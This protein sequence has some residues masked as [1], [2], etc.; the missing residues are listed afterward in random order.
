MPVAVFLQGPHGPFFAELAKKLSKQGVITH[1]INF[2]GGDRFFGWAD[3]QA[4]F[5]GCEHDWPSFFRRYLLEHD[6]EAVFVYGDCRPLHTRARAV[7][8]SLG[9]PFGV[10]EE[11]YLRPDFVTF[12]WGG[13]NAFSHTDWSHEA[14]GRYQSRGRQPG[15]PV[16]RTF[17]QRARFAIGYYLAM[18]FARSK[19]PHYQHHRSRDWKTEGACWIRSFF[20]KGLY[21][22]T[23]RS[24]TPKLTTNFSRKFF[25]FPLQTRDDFQLREHSDLLSMENAIDA[26]LKSFARY[27]PANTVLVIKHHPM[28]RGFCH[29]QKLVDALEARYRLSRRVIYCHDLHLPTLLDHA[30]GVVTINS[31]V[32]ISALLHRVPTK[33]LGRAFYDMRGLTHQGSLSS[34][35]KAPAV[36]EHKLFRR[37]R[38]YLYEQTQLDGSFF[39]GIN[40]TVEGVNER[41]LQTVNSGPSDTLVEAWNI[42]RG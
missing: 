38:T 20:R 13:V 1:K 32:G 22:V 15:A 10:F 19:Y 7:C 6:A 14:I 18:R 35:W 26:V 37:F 3:F 28:D 30:R 29:Y 33:V 39:K 25:L 12:E 11:G 5:S 42:Y 9:I 36:V 17:F 2:N 16:G 27:A 40:K 34:F 8:E 23:Q 4:D 41:L 21:R 24:L 31:T